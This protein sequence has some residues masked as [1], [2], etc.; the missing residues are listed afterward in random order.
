M[1]FV[2]NAENR[3]LFEA[4]LIDMH[5][6]RKTMFVDGL[7]WNI[8]VVEDLE[9]D[10]YDGDDTMYLLGKSVPDGELLVSVRLLPTIG[11]HL[12]SQLFPD[13]TWSSF[14]RGPTV[15]EVSRFCTAPQLHRR[16][17]VQLVV[18]A[19][20]AV[21]ETA[22]L[23]GVEQ[24]VFAVNSALL[25]VTLQCGWQAR[26]LSLTMDDNDDSVTA[27]VASITPEGLRRVRQRFAIAAPVTRFQSG[28]D[29]STKPCLNP[30]AR[31]PSNWQPQ[32]VES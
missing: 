2:V 13:A 6:Q 14:P 29:W 26:K 4:D 21:M 30:T 18:E 23:F 1:I 19:V 17:R 11:P 10:Q 28:F 5:R 32:R 8:P 12:M 16:V 27:V 31:Y 15:W 9:M 25:P 22:L 3:Q 7:G 24:V 20:C